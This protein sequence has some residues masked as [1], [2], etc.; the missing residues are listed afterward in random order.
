M[1]QTPGGGSLNRLVLSIVLDSALQVLPTADVEI[2]TPRVIIVAFLSTLLLGLVQS[3]T[4][5]LLTGPLQ[6][7]S[8]SSLQL[9][10][11]VPTT[12][13]CVGFVGRHP[14]PRLV[15]AAFFWLVLRLLS[16]V[17]YA[18]RLLSPHVSGHEIWSLAEKAEIGLR[19]LFLVLPLVLEAVG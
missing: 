14:K 6:R 15:W 18:H 4:A 7:G 19:Y 5:R 16:L 17:V 3:T 10:A 13:V 1:L 12:V 9:A 11:N 2:G 8:L